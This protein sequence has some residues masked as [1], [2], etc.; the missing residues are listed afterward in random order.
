MKKSV[1][2][3]AVVIGLAMVSSVHGQIWPDM[4]VSS[5]PLASSERFKFTGEIQSMDLKLY[6][7]VVRIGDM[8]YVG[9]LEFAKYEGGYSSLEPLKAGDMVTGEGVI[10][11]GQNCITRIRKAAPGAVPWELRI[12]DGRS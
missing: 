5:D 1:I 8:V 9:H 3:V 2:L 6:T 10:A 4:A 7:A 12:T 11:E